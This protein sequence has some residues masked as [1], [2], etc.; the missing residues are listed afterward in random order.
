MQL[1]CA[2][3]LVEVF[4]LHLLAVL[5]QR[6]KCVFFSNCKVNSLHF[7]SKLPVTVIFN[8]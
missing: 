7:G 4:F 1:K 5:G 6:G 2:S 3:M 8:Q